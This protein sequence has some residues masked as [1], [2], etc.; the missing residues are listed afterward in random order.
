MW[1][2][3]ED[4]AEVP[5]RA[6]LFSVERLAEH[7]G[8]LAQHHQ[9]QPAGLLSMD[10]AAR[11]QASGRI[12]RSCYEAIAE[13]ARQRR[14]VTPAAEWILDNFHVVDE[15]LKSIA[16]DCTPAFQRTLPV[17]REGRL[18]SWPRMY[19]VL[20]SFV[21]HT[22][23]R[24]DSDALT[25]YIRAY[26]SVRPLTLRELWAAPVMLR[27]LFIE[28]LRRIAVRVVDAQ[29]GRRQADAFADDVLGTQAGS[30][31]RLESLLTSVADDVASRAFF[32]QLVHRLRD[33]DAALPSMLERL[34]ARLAPHAINWEE[35][36]RQEHSSQAAANLTVRNLVTSMRAMSALDWQGLVESV[37]LVDACLRRSSEFAR[38]DY[39]T[40]DRYRHAVEELAKNTNLSEVE[41]AQRVVDH[42]RCAGAADDDPRMGDPGYWLIGAGRAAF[43]RQIGYRPSL[44]QRFLRIYVGHATASYL[45]SLALLTTLF[46]G[47][48]LW[49]SATAGVGAAALV[50]LG[51]L[52]A[53]PVSEVAVTLINRWVVGALGPRHLPRLELA[54]AVPAA[55]RTCVA[56]PAILH[57]E[58]DVASSARQLEV[59]FVANSGGD[60]RFALLSDG[61]DADQE[62][63]R[64]DAALVAA[65]AA[66]IDR[67]NRRYGPAPDGG[68]RFFLFHRR[69]QWSPTQG[70]WMGWER[71]RG[72]L[73]EFNRLLRGA[74]DTSFLPLGGKPAKAPEQVKYVVTLD[75]DTRLPIG[76]VAQLVGA[77]AHPLN[78]PR[79]DASAGR[80]V[81]GYGIF[82]PRV[83][84]KLPAASES[85]LFQRLYSAPSGRGSVCGRGVRCLSGSVRRRQLHRQRAV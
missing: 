68:A 46:L 82:Q 19:A 83:T 2:V 71:K 36:M 45:G 57:D 22:D 69:R 15:Q 81:E 48:L 50:V 76:A 11:A 85:S 77:A 73:H 20:L 66:G 29:S 37:S 4:D 12:L 34:N 27:C 54:G 53:I 62:E 38:M 43:E 1:G 75:T 6:E 65:A 10:V 23:S 78:A 52:A 18:R 5:I 24:F 58:A 16:H 72:K 25:A 32:V 39:P 70:K 21:A 42:A 67:L 30:A 60:V 79:L 26:Q 61:V 56:V 13:T 51:V 33:Q 44:R 74:E 8:W 64:E 31:A 41:T 49:A 17:L 35:W 55:L 63:R 3:E 14:V 9:V 59:H 84:P 80:V 47:L 7:A 40:R 28:N